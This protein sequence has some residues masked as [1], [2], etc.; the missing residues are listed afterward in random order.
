[1][2]SISSS[3]DSGERR[4]RGRPQLDMSAVQDANAANASQEADLE[5]SVADHQRKQKKM[6]ASK[7]KTMPEKL[8]I[9][10][11]QLNTQPREAQ[12]SIAEDDT[13]QQQQQQ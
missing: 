5:E 10:Q 3:S 7:R 6:A 8:N 2:S 11:S 4:S 1:M 13:Q 12:G 9:D